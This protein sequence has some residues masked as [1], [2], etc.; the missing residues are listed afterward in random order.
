MSAAA[1]RGRGDLSPISVQQKTWIS[2]AVAAIDN[3]YLMELLT[4]M[5][6]TPSQTG[7]EG[8]LA[9]LLVE[10]LRSRSIPAEYQH[11]TD[12]RGNCIGRVRGSGKGP[13]V[14]MYG[15][16]DTTFTGDED[17]DRPLLGGRARIDLQPKLTRHEGDLL[18]GL[19]INN[20]KGGVAC[21][22]AATDA[23]ARTGVPLGGDVILGLTSGGIHKRPIVA[24][25]RRYEGERYQGYGIGLEF[26][27]KHGVTADFAISTKPGYNI[28]WEEPGQC[29]F[30]VEARGR[31]AYAGLRHVSPHRNPLVDIAHLIIA[32]EAWIPQYSREHTLG[33]LTPQ[34]AVG[35][36]EGG[37][38]FKPEF[39][40]DMA[41]IYVSLNT[42]SKITPLEMRRIFGRFIDRYRTEH[43]DVDLSWEMTQLQ[44]GSK[45][46][47]DN[48]IVKSCRRAWETVEGRIQEDL[49]GLSGTTDG[50]ILRHWGIPT[51]RLG[52]PGLMA[53][54][55]GWPPMYDVTRASD[56]R[57]LTE[58]YVHAI[59][60][61][62]TREELK[63]R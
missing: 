50:N 7:R 15:H 53:P 18:T 30:M 41:R 58:C 31:L 4:R 25:N 52:L 24:L 17:D 63:G 46:D 57:R 51:V 6:E 12:N 16:L 61:T 10:Q 1:A 45:T 14:L 37:W 20:P 47:P 49:T 55:K 26:M 27:L 22:I 35:A 3:D 28:V 39:I 44:A 34:G 33:Q 59:I 13:D 62:C 11:I 32:L 42:N 40:P 5:V 2:E 43:Q 60:D 8:P 29:W 38:P 54:E 23:I 56:L 48:W 36:V 21:A 9:A 19:G